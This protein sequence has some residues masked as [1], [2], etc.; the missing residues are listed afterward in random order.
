MPTEEDRFKALVENGY[1]IYRRENGAGSLSHSASLA[2]AADWYAGEMA[3][4]RAPFEHGNWA[5]RIRRFI[6]RR[7]ATGAELAEN[8][9][10][11]QDSPQE[12]VRAWINS[13]GHER[14]MRDKTFR[15]IGV[16]FARQGDTEY[17][18]VDLGTF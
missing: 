9:A 10:Y 3:A 18:V 8:I 2:K 15:K 6:G 1:N 13:P 17:W 7:H 11:G 14:N 5:K 16:G 4:G 12:V